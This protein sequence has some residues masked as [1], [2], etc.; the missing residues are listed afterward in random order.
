MGQA[1]TSIAKRFILYILIFSTVITTLLTAIQ[2][3]IDYNNGLRQIQN[4]LEVVHDSHL[5]GLIN[6]LWLFDSAALEIQLNGMLKLNDMQ[7][8]RIYSDDGL[9]LKV[10]EIAH[11]DHLISQSFPL[12]KEYDGQL[13]ELGTL[14]VHFTLTRLYQRL[15]DKA[16]VILLTQGIKTF[17]VSFFIFVIFYQLVG[18]HL[19]HISDWVSR[20]RLTS[21][22]DAI[23]LERPGEP[24]DELQSMVN[25]FNRLQ[26]NIAR[27]T[28]QLRMFRQQLE[29]SRDALYVIEA[30]SGRIL[31]VNRAACDM[32]GYA[33]EELI[34][35]RVH[36]IS[37]VL[38][39][40]QAE[41]QQMAEATRNT[42]AGVIFEDEHIS[43]GGQRIPVEISSIFQHNT[44]GDVFVCGVR[45][46][47]ERKRAQQALQFQAQHDQLTSL[48]NRYLLHDR[49]SQMIFEARRNH[50]SLILLFIDLDHFKHINDSYG[51]SFGDKVLLETAQRLQQ[52]VRESDTLARLG[53]DEFVALARIQ[54]RPETYSDFANKMLEAF[55][56][57]YQIDETRLLVH[58]SIGVC[59]YP[60]DGDS[61]ELLLRNAD[62]AM[63][64]AKN[65]GRNAFQFYSPEL[66]ELAERRILLQQE[67]DQALK[68]QQLIPYFQPQ[69]DSKTRRVIGAEALV[70]WQHPERGLVPPG[71]FIAIAEQTGQIRQIDQYMLNRVCEFIT[72][73]LQQGIVLPRISVNFSGK[74]IEASLFCEEITAVLKHY[75]CPCQQIE[76]EI[77][78]SQIMRN[79]EQCIGEL[80]RLRQRGIRLAVDDFGTGYSS[81][82]YLKKLPIDK[83]KIDQ[84]FVRNTPKDNADCSIVRSIIALGQNLD[85][86]LLAE[87]VETP[88][89]QSF[90]R[91]AG[92]AL[93]QGYL[94]SKPLAEE[95]FLN[96][97]KAQKA[98]LQSA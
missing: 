11:L 43:I 56:Q 42:P 6:S 55:R 27:D 20:F 16:L 28:Q 9:D 81:L 33:A 1:R 82:S 63:Y 69:I 87:G 86:E 60:Q 73:N 93:Q 98:P 88:E 39:D 38:M 12:Q 29:A 53:G 10:G 5:D 92:C 84:S 61:A 8:L 31:D 51:H 54:A 47:N 34:G 90:L 50:D 17:L 75:Q 35:M 96:F 18:K 58:C 13:I 85:L 83:L 15:L 40:G 37:A 97:L 52:N 57:P 64:K 4:D 45:D 68:Q 14:E 76:I 67:L 80:E 30:A 72:R 44:R 7:Y 65:H 3:R 62:A 23:H 41:F 70:R 24:D 71:E 77:T 95:V 89:Q 48:P 36:E 66:T 46:I 91:E 74:E 79:P 2:L 78:E 94:Y 32:L 21:R 25:A 26:H 59:I 22:A 19:S 49:I